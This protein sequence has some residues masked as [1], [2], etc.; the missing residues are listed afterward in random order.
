M[1]ESA[2]GTLLGGVIVDNDDEPDSAWLTAEVR[3]SELTRGSMKQVYE[4]R[5]H[6]W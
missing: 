5:D 3:R 1:R 4:V 6:L 2:S